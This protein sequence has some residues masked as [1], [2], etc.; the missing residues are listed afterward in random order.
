MGDL[1]SVPGLGRSPGDV[2]LQHT[3]VFWPGEF[4]GQ[5]SLAGSSPRGHEELDMT[6][7]LKKKTRE[8]VL[9]IRST[10]LNFYM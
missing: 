9:N 10:L 1:G 7:E 6:E 4:Y 3:L 5:R 2:E 8:R